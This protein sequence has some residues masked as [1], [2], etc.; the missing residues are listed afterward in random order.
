MR[1]KKCIYYISN[2]RNLGLWKCLNDDNYINLYRHNNEY[3]FSLIFSFSK[4]NYGD[5][6]PGAYVL[7]GKYKVKEKWNTELRYWE[8]FVYKYHVNAYYMNEKIG[9]LGS[10]YP[11]KK[12]TPYKIINYIKKIEQLSKPTNIIGTENFT[13]V[14]KVIYELSSKENPE[15]ENQYLRRYSVEEY[16]RQDEKK[17]GDEMLKRCYLNPFEFE[18]EYPELIKESEKKWW[19][20][21]R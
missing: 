19:H 1:D 3:Y 10:G 5:F 18:K 21:F 4:G 16:L 20:F 2:D 9:R 17:Y 12:A 14:D 11:I 15:S 6:L 8:P 7:I 13:W